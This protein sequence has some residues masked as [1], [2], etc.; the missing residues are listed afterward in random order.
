MSIRSLLGIVGISIIL[1]ACSLI[2]P[3]T[4]ENPSTVPTSNTVAPTPA[5]LSSGTVKEFTMTASQWKFDPATIMV[6]Q[7]NTVRLH[8]KD[9]DVEHGFRLNAFNINQ[10]LLPGSTT[11]V[12]FVANKTGTFP[13]S[14][15]VACGPGHPNM[16]G[17]L[18][19]Q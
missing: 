11:T 16:T 17:T 3:P 12:E 5:K 4:G 8:I 14:C 9:T 15:S 13:F 18:V 10:D 2:P 19:V 7:G 6:S 1:T